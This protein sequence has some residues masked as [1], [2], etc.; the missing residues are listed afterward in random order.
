MVQSGSTLP[1]PQSTPCSLLTMA[2]TCHVT[3]DVKLVTGDLDAATYER[4]AASPTIAWDI[5]TTG[6]DWQG[7]EIATVQICDRGA[8]V[9]VR[10]LHARPERLARLTRGQAPVLDPNVGLLSLAQRALMS[11]LWRERPITPL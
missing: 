5:E 7:D 1:E 10:Q 6:L 9:I 11:R 3:T 8:V 2:T 4:L